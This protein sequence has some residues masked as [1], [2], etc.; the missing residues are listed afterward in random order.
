MVNLF[1]DKTAGK[2]NMKEIKKYEN[3]K[4]QPIQ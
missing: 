1:Q 3:R 4:T 2:L